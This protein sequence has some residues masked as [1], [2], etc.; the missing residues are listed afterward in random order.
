MK[1]TIKILNPKSYYKGGG[2][3]FCAL[4]YIWVFSFFQKYTQKWVFS[5]IFRNLH[6]H[7][8]FVVICKKVSIRERRFADHLEWTFF[9]QIWQNICFFFK[10][11]SVFQKLSSKKQNTCPFLPFERSSFSQKHQHESEYFLSPDVR[12]KMKNKYL[13][14]LT[15]AQNYVY[16]YKLKSTRWWVFSVRKKDIRIFVWRG[17]GDYINLCD[18]FKVSKFLDRFF[19]KYHKQNQHVDE[20]LGLFNFSILA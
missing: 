17:F 12:V 6:I 1:P 4:R 19:G 7:E 10:S 18:N 13:W 3:L 8:Y 5:K 16:F 15:S 2:Q 9:C 14:L 20:F 11:E